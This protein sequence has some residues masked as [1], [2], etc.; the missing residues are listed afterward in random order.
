MKRQRWSVKL[1]VPIYLN[2]QT[3][4]G[5]IASLVPHPCKKANMPIA[6][7]TSFFDFPVHMKVVLIPY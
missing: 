7:D 1:A 2:L 5:D 4:F 3:L 6:T